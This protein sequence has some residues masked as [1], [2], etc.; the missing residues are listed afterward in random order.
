MGEKNNSARCWWLTPVIL[1]TWEVEI[2]R[3]EVWGQP[4]K[5]VQEF[6]STRKKPKNKKKP[7]QSKMD[8]RC[9]SQW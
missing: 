3:L 6:S 1:A 2:R 9:S 4:V 7:K 5:I 8:W